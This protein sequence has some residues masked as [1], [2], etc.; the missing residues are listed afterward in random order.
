ME[1]RAPASATRR[2]GK[3]RL[4]LPAMSLRVVSIHAETCPLG[5][6][7]EGGWEPC[8]GSRTL[9][10]TKIFEHHRRTQK[11]AGSLRRVSHFRVT[12]ASPSR[13]CRRSSSLFM[14]G[15]A[16]WGPLGREAGSHALE[17]V[18]STP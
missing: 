16:R 17:V 11:P 14:M 15:G 8:A 3:E 18:L 6:A 5:A 13:R 7:T 10:H 1:R 4:S 9:H 12:K 2:G